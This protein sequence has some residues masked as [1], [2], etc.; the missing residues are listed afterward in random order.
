MTTRERRDRP[1]KDDPQCS[2]CGRRRSE[3]RRM[4]R[5]HDARVCDHCVQK[6][7]DDDRA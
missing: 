6:F 3:V 4:F 5:S 2:F 1:E 7:R